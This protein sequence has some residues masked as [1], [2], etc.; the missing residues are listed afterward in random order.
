MYNNLDKRA[1]AITEL[2]D[3]ICSNPNA[4]SVVELSLDPSFHRTHDSVYKA[5]GKFSIEELAELTTCVIPENRQKQRIQLLVD[6]TYAPREYAYTLEDRGFVYKPTV[7]KGNKPITIGH[8]YSTIVYHP[9]IKE[10]Q[11]PHW[12]SPISVQRVTTDEKKSKVA[13]RQIE[14]IMKSPRFAESNELVTI[15]GDSDY[16]RVEY[17]HDNQQHENVICVSRVR[18]NR[19]LYQSHVPTAEEK[20]KSKKGRPKKYG[21]K[22]RLPDPETWHTPSS[23]IEFEAHTKKGEPYIVHVQQWDNMLMRGKNKPK[24]MAMSDHPFSL[25][26]ITSIDPVTGEP[27]YAKA[28]WLIV[29]G[30]RRNELSLKDSYDC[31]DERYDIEHFFRFAKQKLLLDSYQ[32]PQVEYEENW[33]KM[34]HLAY[35]QLWLASE[36]AQP[37]PRPWEDHLE[38]SQNQIATPATVQ[39]DFPRIK[40]MFE[41]NPSLPKPRGNSSGSQKGVTRERRTRHP[42]IKKGDKKAD[43]T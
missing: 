6:V 16:S 36:Q 19:T 20:S 32:T 27:K 23:E 1:D 2:L 26:R 12:V 3:A 41:N 40:S 21:E 39:R 29:M 33:W 28:L 34:V 4:R 5:I 7:I 18:S 9:E 15:A 13:V 35:L 11:S 10:K 43:T 8:Q 24:R 42:V 38:T 25:I 37:E 22:F 30:K 17:L 14:S 31:Y